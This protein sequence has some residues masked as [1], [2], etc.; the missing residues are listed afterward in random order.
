MNPQAQ[1]PAPR[2][3]AAD[4]SGAGSY[5]SS[6]IVTPKEIDL[7][8]DEVVDVITGAEHSLHEGVSY[9]EAFQVPVSSPFRV[10]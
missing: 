4:Q 6:M 8:I 5:F 7:L 2:S 9:D 1:P 3:Q 10:G